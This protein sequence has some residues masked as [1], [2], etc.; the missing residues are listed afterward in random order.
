MSQKQA[1]KMKKL[2]RQHTA[3]EDHFPQPEPAQSFPLLRHRRLVEFEKDEKGMKR[4]TTA[5]PSGIVKDKQSID[6]IKR[7][8]ARTNRR[9]EK[10]TGN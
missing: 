4:K 10:V 8:Q 9:Q 6:D 7:T 5:I 3:V 2:L 1:K